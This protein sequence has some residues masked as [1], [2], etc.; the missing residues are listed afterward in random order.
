[1][2]DLLYLKSTTLE[3]KFTS[4][5]ALW[6]RTHVFFKS[7]R[8]QLYKPDKAC[9]E[10]EG[11]VFYYLHV[12]NTYLEGSPCAAQYMLQCLPTFLPM[13]LY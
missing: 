1:M 8:Y 12:N 2:A 5:A 4:V 3:S 11:N 7:S 6:P 13:C 10:L 9:D